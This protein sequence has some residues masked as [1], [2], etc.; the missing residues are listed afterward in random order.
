M[1]RRIVRHALLLALLGALGVEGIAWVRVPLAEFVHLAYPR[2]A[3][4]DDGAIVNYDQEESSTNGQTV[5]TTYYLDEDRHVIGTVG[6]GKVALVGQRWRSAARVRA[7]TFVHPGFLLRTRIGSALREFDLAVPV[8]PLDALARDLNVRETERRRPIGLG[9]NAG[10]EA[11]LVYPPPNLKLEWGAAAGRLVCREVASGRVLAGLGPDGF[12][13]GDRGAEGER[14]GDLAGCAVTSKGGAAEYVMLESD[15]RR[16]AVVGVPEGK[17]A[18]PDSIET[19]DLAVEMR[20]LRPL[21]ASD[22]GT[23]EAI[24]WIALLDNEHVLFFG[25][26]AVFGRFALGPDEWIHGASKVRPLNVVRGSWD[27]ED[28]VRKQ[29]TSRMVVGVE[30]FEGPVPPDMERRRL[31]LFRPGQEPIEHDVTLEPARA[32]EYLPANVA[33]SLALLRPF[34]LSIASAASELP[35]RWHGWWWRDPWLAGG[36][37]QGWL[38]ASL[39]LAAFCGW[40][41]RRAARQRCATVRE[42]R[43]WTAAVF[44]LG[45]VGLLWMRFVLPRVP[46]EAVGQ[47]RRAVNLD[48]SPSTDAPWP[49]P[50]PLGIEVFS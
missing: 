42:V 14:F 12:V 44:L 24:A 29:P 3:L 33:A 38:V 43:F 47:A 11:R 50:K 6:R 22:D 36:R 35:A 4:L 23:R 17:F 39:A 18:P 45:P 5:V 7:F 30:A 34:P 49:D 21:D 27:W 26:G 25:D 1:T 40:R 28:D 9:G 32:S 10:R 16:L 19:L 8:G 13:R 31:R 41:A 37:Y 20:P 15:T 46:V 48:S 2:V